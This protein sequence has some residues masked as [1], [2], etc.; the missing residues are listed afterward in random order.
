METCE[1]L[2]YM[3]EGIIERNLKD[4]GMEGQRHY[5]MERTGALDRCISGIE[6]SDMLP[7]EED[8]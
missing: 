2:L 1:E 8:E 5:V 3:I 4:E 7:I 6:Q